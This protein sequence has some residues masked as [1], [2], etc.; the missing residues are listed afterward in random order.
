MDVVSSASRIWTITWSGMT[1][2]EAGDMLMPEESPA[3]RHDHN[4]GQVQNWKLMDTY[5]GSQTLCLLRAVSAAWAVHGVQGH[6]YSGN[7]YSGRA[8]LCV[9]LF[10]MIFY[11]SS[12]FC[13]DLWLCVFRSL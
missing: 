5:R 9:R 6:A 10:Y 7:C 11:D 8:V 13:I 2:H 3:Q 1:R 12:R 4:V